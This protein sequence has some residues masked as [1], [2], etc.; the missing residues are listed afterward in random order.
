MKTIKD[1]LQA[2]SIE[3]RRRILN[4]I[5][6]DKDSKNFIVRGEAAQANGEGSEDENNSLIYYKKVLGLYDDDQIE[7]I[8]KTVGTYSHIVVIVTGND[9]REFSITPATIC[10]LNDNFNII[11]GGIIL[12]QEYIMGETKIPVN[13]LDDI[14]AMMSNS[15]IAKEVI[16]PISKEEF[17]ELFK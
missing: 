15:N 3:Q 17:Y 1:A 9:E 7:N 12:K 16:I 11:L 10:A 6:I 4:N 14:F 5:G 8:V 13:S 2:S